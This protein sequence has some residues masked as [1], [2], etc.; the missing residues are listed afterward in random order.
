MKKIFTL[1]LSTGIITVAVAQ[2]TYHND[3]NKNNGY[4]KPGGVTMKDNRSTSD[5]DRFD[6]DSYFMKQKM[7]ME[8]DRINDEFNRKIQGVQRNFFLSRIQ[9]E[10]KVRKLEDQRQDKIK[11]VYRKYHFNY[12]HDFDHDGHHH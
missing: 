8:I 12:D 1:L 5:K 3:W 6:K 4:G 7:D 9:K 2:D 10:R 11:D